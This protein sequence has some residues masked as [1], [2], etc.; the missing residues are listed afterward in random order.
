MESITYTARLI[1]MWFVLKD[2]WLRL[3]YWPRF[4]ILVCDTA[5]IWCFVQCI[6]DHAPGGNSLK[7][8]GDPGF[9]CHF[10]ARAATVTLVTAC[11]CSIIYQFQVKQQTAH[12]L[13]DIAWCNKLTIV[14]GVLAYNKICNKIMHI[15]Y[16]N[17]VLNVDVITKQATTTVC[18]SRALLSMCYVRDTCC[19]YS[20]KDKVR[21]T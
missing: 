2:L 7:K 14:V 19:K 9:Y 1:K 6:S 18:F 15:L 20:L 3:P 17:T 5:N 4:E 16:C 21:K 10:I 11:T 8:M 12:Y 13:L